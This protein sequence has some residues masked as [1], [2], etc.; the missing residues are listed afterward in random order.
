MRT[1]PLILLV[2]MSVAGCSGPP[3]R[4]SSADLAGEWTNPEGVVMTFQIAGLAVA[5]RPGSK[6]RALFSEYTFDGTRVTFRSRPESQLCADEVGQYDARVTG[7]TCV[8]TLVWDACTSRA[9]LLQ[10]TWAR[11]SPDRAGAGGSH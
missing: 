7:D 3:P 5:E 9:R 10:G 1:H 2:L 6:D 4:V 11:T 8:L